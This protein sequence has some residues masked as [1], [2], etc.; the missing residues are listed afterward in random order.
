[1][2]GKRKW[3]WNVIALVLVTGLTPAA[4][5][6]EQGLVG[7]W[8]LQGDAQDHSGHGNHAV[9]HGVR[10][11]EG[12]F[13]GMGAYLEIPSSESLQM[14][15][16][17]FTFAARIF[18]PEQLGDIVGDVLDCYDPARRRGVT[19][20][21]KPSSGGY[22]SQGTDRHV[23]FGIDDDRLGQWVDC[24][25]P[26]PT[27]SYVSNS[28]TVFDGNL[29]AATMDAA[30]E[31]GR[32]RVYRYEGGKSWADCGQLGDG[33]VSGVLPMIVHNGQLYAGTSTYDWTRVKEG[34]YDPG[35]VY[36]YLGGQ[37]W[38]DIGQPSDNR[39][40][41]SLASYQGKLY[42]GGGPDTWGVFVHED[43]GQWQSAKIFSKQGPQR[44]FPHA[45]SLHNGKLFVAYP[46]VYQFDG[47][48][49]KFIGDPVQFGDRH[50]NLQTHAMDLY[51]GKL[52]AGAFPEAIVSAYLGG[53]GWQPMGRVGEDATEVLSL[54]VYNGQLYGSSL[55]RAEVCRYEGN[56]KWT[57]LKRFHSPDG[58]VPG[59]PPNVTRAQV[60]EM[61]RVTSL[62][63]YDGKMFAST[64][65]CTGAAQD[66]PLDVRGKVFSLEAGKSASYDGDLGPGWKHLTAVR[67]GG[68][69]QIY[70]DGK[71]AAKST[72][73]DP[74]HYDVSTDQPLR[75][76]FGQTE[77]FEGKMADVR[78]YNRALSEQ[79]IT[80]LAQQP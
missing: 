79:E 27:C 71:L 6:A 70:I 35:R 2:N 51:Q 32:R 26:N 5:A 46:G 53:D 49:W 73:F 29:Y 74:S 3:S 60:N 54:V 21:I 68:E 20:T 50:G 34:G 64:A 67:R 28:L 69:L 75:L 80:D 78:M 77:Y 31:S 40:L 65:S 47:N 66:S 25:R 39:T 23:H 52:L 30:D 41:N 4:R 61:A 42:V 7:H 37:R 72:A 13:D 10:L 12:T 24:G 8:K 44:C 63:Q 18:T 14:G 56:S 22:Q 57:S 58:W 1:M 62:T 9:N 55:P 38:E 15:T 43:A 36:R 59:I 45:M 17:D 76:G 33:N 19:L 11:D 48:E 16:G